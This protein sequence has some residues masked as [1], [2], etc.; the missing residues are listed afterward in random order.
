MKFPICCHTIL[1][2]RH[3]SYI[4]SYNIFLILFSELSPRKAPRVK[5]AFVKRKLDSLSSQRFLQSLPTSRV[6]SAKQ[7]TNYRFAI[8][9][10]VHIII[11]VVRGMPHQGDP[12][13]W[14]E[15]QFFSSAKDTIVPRKLVF[16]HVEDLKICPQKVFFARIL[17][18]IT[19]IQNAD[20][21]SQGN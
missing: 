8:K 17:Y 3:R 7:H 14:S 1:S 13:K 10:G 20:P 5:D 19:W 2:F 9:T 16:V 15:N 18:R 6:F 4:I 11:I 21:R 12:I